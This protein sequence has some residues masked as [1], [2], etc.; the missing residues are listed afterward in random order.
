MKTTRKRVSLMVIM[1][2]AL[3]SC[4]TAEV[5]TKAPIKVKAISGARLIGNTLDSELD[6]QTLDVRK[7]I[8]D[9]K[10]PKQKI[11]L[12]GNLKINTDSFIYI[13]LSKINLPVAK[14]L[15]TPQK[16]TMVSY[17]P[18][19][20]V[21]ESDY[22][23]LSKLLN[24]PVNYYAI[25]SILSNKLFNVHCGDIYAFLTDKKLKRKQNR[26]IRNEFKSFYSKRDSFKYV[27][28]DWRPKKVESFNSKQKKKERL[29]KR[30]R[31][32]DLLY[33]QFV[34]HPNMFK[35]EK[36]LLRD[37][38]LGRSLEV[39]YSNFKPLEME[40][41]PHKLQTTFTDL[42]GKTTIKV[43]LDRFTVD[44]PLQIN[45]RVPDR[46]KRIKTLVP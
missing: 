46:Y 40:M 41:F 22:R 42:K 9:Y 20:F 1:A 25:Q 19:K 30:K 12:R 11:G 17:K 15:M 36:Y 3:F 16:F 37:L 2:L 8:I 35:V 21:L 13:S 33:Q 39:K 32:N 43:Q 4:K 44:K 18:D 31:S 28:H 29:V 6:F 24:T 23:E 10:S 26:L 38:L 34:V 5:I 27:L 7:L 14:I 45:F